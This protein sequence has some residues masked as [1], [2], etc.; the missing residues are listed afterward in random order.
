MLAAWLSMW[1]KAKLSIKVWQHAQSAT[2]YE[3]LNAGLDKLFAVRRN[4][5]SSKYE[6]ENVQGHFHR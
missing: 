3:G 5:N 2:T 1:L 6:K 4:V